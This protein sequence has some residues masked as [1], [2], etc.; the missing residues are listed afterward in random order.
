MVVID[1]PGKIFG[2]SFCDKNDPFLPFSD[3]KQLI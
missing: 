1:K 2:T 3:F